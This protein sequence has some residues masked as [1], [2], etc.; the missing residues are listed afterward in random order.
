MAEWSKA[1][2]LRSFISGCVGSNPTSCKS[3]IY[4]KFY[5]FYV[6]IFNIKRIKYKN[7]QGVTEETTYE[8]TNNA[9]KHEELNPLYTC[10]FVFNRVLSDGESVFGGVLASCS[11]SALVTK[12][13]CVGDGE[14]PQLPHAGAEAES[15]SIDNFGR[16]CARPLSL[17]SLVADVSKATILA[18]LPSTSE[19]AFT[20][21]I[22]RWN[23][24]LSHV[25]ALRTAISAR[26]PTRINK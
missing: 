9:C 1:N 4:I 23:F 22:S 6:K 17:R 21:S 8:G 10:L 16:F 5:L 20:F 11:N 19:S 2:D 3:P 24:L 14:I 12:A 26:G 7:G 13:R 15:G 18:S 25:G